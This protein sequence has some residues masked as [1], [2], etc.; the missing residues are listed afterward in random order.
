MSDEAEAMRYAQA[1]GDSQGIGA[2]VYDDA[3]YAGIL[4]ELGLVNRATASD[5]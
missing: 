5:E 3:E 2:A 1:F 4:D